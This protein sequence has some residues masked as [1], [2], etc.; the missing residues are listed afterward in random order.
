MLQSVATAS[1]GPGFDYHPFDDPTKSMKIVLMLYDG[2]IGYL[3]KALVYGEM[4][5]LKNRNIL[6]NKTR[7]VIAELDGGLDEAI[8]GDFAIKL[9]QL[10]VF[11]REHL[12]KSIHSQDDTQPINDVIKI[13]SSIRDSWQD[14]EK[15]FAV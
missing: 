1:S 10:Y 8:G 2:A 7:D 12:A 5:D 11:M 4:G 15:Q 3:R 13:L 14:V 9:R 6:I